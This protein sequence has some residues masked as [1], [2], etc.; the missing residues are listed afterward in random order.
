MR[1]GSKHSVQNGICSTNR[2]VTSSRAEVLLFC[3]LIFAVAASLSVQL[4][5]LELKT[6]RRRPQLKRVL[7]IFKLICALDAD[8]EHRQVFGIGEPYTE[9]PPKTLDHLTM[10]VDVRQ[11][12]H[13]NSFFFEVL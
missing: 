8:C 1:W 9:D 12:S 3:S 7:A 6:L 13:F 11:I 4:S 5:H 2:V 10:F